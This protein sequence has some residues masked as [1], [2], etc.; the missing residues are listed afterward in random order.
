MSMTFVSAI[1]IHC[2]SSQKP[3][4]EFR[5]PGDLGTLQ[6]K[7]KMG[8]HKAPSMNAIIEEQDVPG[9]IF[10]EFVLILFIPKRNIA[11]I[12]SG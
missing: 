5:Q 4:H 2:V 8:W 10:Q 6:E 11:G 7:V 9:K 1:V 3:A 12:G